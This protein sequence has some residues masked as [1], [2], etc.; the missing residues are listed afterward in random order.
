MTVSD[1]DKGWRDFGK[2]IESLQGT[3]PHTLVGVQGSDASA[4][5]GSGKTNADIASYNEFGTGHIPARSFIRATIDRHEGALLKLCAQL[6]QA[7]VDGKV[8][9]PQALGLLGEQTRGLMIQRITAHIAP[10]NAPETIRRKGSSTPLIAF[11]GALKNSINYR[12]VGA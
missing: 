2:R 12:V 4:S 7:V 1:I 3:D 5:H 10:P 8:Q 6:G 11:T 9:T